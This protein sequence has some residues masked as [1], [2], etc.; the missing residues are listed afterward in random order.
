MRVGE[1]EVRARVRE[2]GD[3]DGRGRVKSNEE[4]KAGHCEVREV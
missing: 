2:G 4:C 1:S 3:R